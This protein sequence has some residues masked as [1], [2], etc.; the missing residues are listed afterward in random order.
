MLYEFR[1]NV[2]LEHKGWWF[3][4]ESSWEGF[5]PIDSVHWDGTT[6][7][8]DDRAYCTDPM[9]NLYGYG[10]QQM[11]DLCNLLKNKREDTPNV[12]D[13]LNFGTLEWFRDRRV[14]IG[15]CAPRTLDS[16][17]RMIHK[18]HRTCRKAPRGKKFT[19]RNC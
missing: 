2:F 13:A 8:I 9:D 5:R 11:K 18:K 10:S 14:C 7:A 19:R 4:W 15:Q 6:F 17:K 12:V 3:L 16:W 1:D